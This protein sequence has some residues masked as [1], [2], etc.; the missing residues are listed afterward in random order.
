MPKTL[1]ELQQF[2]LDLIERATRSER[3]LFKHLTEAGI[4]FKFQHII[5]FYIV[6]FLLDKNIVIELDGK[7]H[8]SRVTYDRRRDEYLRGLGYKILRIASYRIFKEKRKVLEEIQDFLSGKE[9][10]RMRKP[11]TRKTKVS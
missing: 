5:N 7:I 2:R 6:D 3:K 4:S 8:Q 10:V 11:Y 1:K 9:I